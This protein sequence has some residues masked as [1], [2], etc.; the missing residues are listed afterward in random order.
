MLLEN[1]NNVFGVQFDSYYDKR[2]ECF[3]TKSIFLVAN[4][5]TFVREHVLCYFSKSILFVSFLVVLVPIW[6]CKVEYKTSKSIK[7]IS[8]IKP[9]STFLKGKK[10]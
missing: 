8:R 10:C 2:K 1:K 6:G 4:E 7:K 3:V 9:I 5:H